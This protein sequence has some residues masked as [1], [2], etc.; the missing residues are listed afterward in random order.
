MVRVEPVGMCVHLN[1][2]AGCVWAQRKCN[3]LLGDRGQLVLGLMKEEGEVLTLTFLLFGQQGE[4]TALSRR[5]GVQG[6]HRRKNP[7]LDLE[8]QTQRASGALREASL[9][10]ELKT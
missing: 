2:G 10:V 3:P 1:G 9:N 8:S 4:S 6:R 5:G 7:H